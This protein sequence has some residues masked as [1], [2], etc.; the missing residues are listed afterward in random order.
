MSRMKT[1]DLAG[2]TFMEMDLSNCG[3]EVSIPTILEAMA[4][5]KSQPRNSVILLSNVTGTIQ[6]KE[7]VD[8]LKDFAV[9]NTPYVKASAV[10]GID[11]AKKPIL[12]TIQFLTLHEIKPFESETEAREWLNKFI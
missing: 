6:T 2:K 1:V 10:L 9:S 5:I 7:V 12:T 8:L 11:A 4:L 3:P